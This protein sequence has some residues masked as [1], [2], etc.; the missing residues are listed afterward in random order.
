MSKRCHGVLIIKGEAYACDLAIEH[1]G[2]AHSN[3][4]AE[5]IWLGTNNVESHLPKDTGDCKCD[6]YE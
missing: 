5:A 2:W 6:D 4:E 3:K 1:N